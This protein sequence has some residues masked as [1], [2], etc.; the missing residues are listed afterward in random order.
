MSS[1]KQIFIASSKEARRVAERLIE[2][3]N[4]ELI[5]VPW[6]TAFT[7][8][9]YT[10]ED[11][12]RH[13]KTVDGAIIIAAKDD[14]VW[15]RNQLGG[16]PRD[17]VIL[18]FGLFAS[19]LGL[20]RTI[21]LAEQGV[22]LPSDLRGVTY[23]T[24]KKKEI[25]QTASDIR[26]HFWKEFESDRTRR[27]QPLRVVSHPKI[28]SLQ[29]SDSLPKQW[30][31]RAM[32]LGT[33]GARAWLE[34]ANDPQYEDPAERAHLLACV[35]ELLAS[36]ESS[37]RTY[38]SLGPGDAQLDRGVALAILEKEPSAQ[39][40]PVDLSD[41]LLWKAIETLSAHIRVPV[42]LLADF[43]EQFDFISDHV[44]EYGKG[45][46]IYSL[47]GGTFGSLD[48]SELVFVQNLSTCMQPGDEFILD[49]T[50]VKEGEKSNS[51]KWGDGTKR[52][53][54]HGATRHSKYSREEIIRRFD[55]IVSVRRSP[56]DGAI[57]GTQAM[58][59]YIDEKPFARARR[60]VLNELTRF[61]ERSGF[62]ARSKLI[63]VDGPY[64][65]GILSLIKK[66]R[67]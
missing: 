33:E 58:T 44:R 8:G 50:V 63:E 28:A 23:L 67:R 26:E 34:T 55:E 3:L 38:V 9:E 43:E 57:A 15:Y 18:E 22:Q 19:R 56:L 54:S 27:E 11:L 17:N 46:Y 7:L 29:I 42:G 30:L 13:S 66:A 65:I 16:R 35:M 37:F 47:F 51:T 14:R 10:F 31:M 21:I 49:V 45:P 61:F 41:G 2:Q 60:Y 6:W 64:N 40:I 25:D 59:L 36:A 4:G 1:Q 53:F 32:Y 5:A 48:G 24:L 20:K 12:T 39:C 52:F 62:Q